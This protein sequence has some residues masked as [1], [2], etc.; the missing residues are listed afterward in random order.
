VLSQA[1]EEATEWNPPVR[2]ERWELVLRIADSP[3]FCRSRRLREFLLYIC[4]RT[5]ENAVDDLK[6]QRIGCEVFRRSPE[7]NPAEDNIVRV[8]ARLLRRRLAEYFSEEGQNERLTLTVPKGS[9]LPVFQS[10][11]L[12]VS[13]GTADGG[14]QSEAVSSD[15][16]N[17]LQSLLLWRVLA[18]GLALATVLVSLALVEQRHHSAPEIGSTSTTSPFW[19]TIFDGR[20][21][22]YIVCGDSALA[23]LQD[24]TRTHVS[25]A[26]YISRRY[27]TADR[28]IAPDTQLLA[29]VLPEK[30]YTSV[31]DIYLVAKLLKIS[32][33]ADD[34]VSVRTAR[35]LSME[36]FKS[37]NFILL[38]SSRAN[39]WGELFEPQL[40]FIWEF[41]AGEAPYIRNAHPKAGE[42][43]IYFP[44]GRAY[45]ATK[46]YDVVAYMPNLG[47]TGNV[48]MIAGTSLIGT[49]A[50]GEYVMGGTG[51][52]RFLT[53][54]IE[55]NKG[56]I[57]YFEILL[58][59]DVLAG[60]PKSS[61][62]VAYRVLNQQ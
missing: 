54:L 17:F 15:H 13:T 58:R 8:E 50:A 31:A 36:D 47:H 43:A 39:P 42:Q 20:N 19:R 34:R 57:P 6:E 29:S 52:Q 62:I 10:R 44:I 1:C 33:N 5:L 59:S 51:F 18:C 56:K 2:D 4:C 3:H 24:L 48:L 60:A 40:N 16:R 45:S 37:N 53:S 32:G 22:T 41:P 30:Q 26:D 23:L 46:T 7:Y 14:S 38:G 11:E 21:R 35:S 12:T 9:Y 55:K 25:L 27:G 61:E 49:E 28:A